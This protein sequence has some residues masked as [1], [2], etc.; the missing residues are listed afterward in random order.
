MNNNSF[1]NIPNWAWSM[2]VWYL[3]KHP[4]GTVSGLKKLIFRKKK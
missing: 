1:H 4:K 3:D 2:Y